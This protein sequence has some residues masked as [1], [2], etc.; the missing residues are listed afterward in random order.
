MWSAAT[1]HCDCKVLVFKETQLQPCRWAAIAHLEQALA[2]IG[3]RHLWHLLEEKKP[4]RLRRV[5][6]WKV[7]KISGAVTVAEAAASAASCTA[8]SSVVSSTCAPTQVAVNT[9]ANAQAE[10]NDLRHEICRARTR[11]AECMQ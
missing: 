5:P 3:I 2:T 9:E 6:T 10:R 7:L 8:I 11:E 1:T 4:A